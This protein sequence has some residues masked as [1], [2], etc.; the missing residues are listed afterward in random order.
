MHPARTMGLATLPRTTIHAVA[1]LD[2]K[3]EIV[4]VRISLI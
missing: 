1:L 3:G 4:K 2:L